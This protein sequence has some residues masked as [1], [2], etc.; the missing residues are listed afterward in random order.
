MYCEQ[1]IRKYVSRWMKG[2]NLVL[3]GSRE[4]GLAGPLSDIDLNI[5]LPEFEGLSRRAPTFLRQRTL[6]H[7]TLKSLYQ[8]FLSHPVDRYDRIQFKPSRNVSVLDITDRPTG[9]IIQFTCRPE[10]DSL[11]F[12]KYYMEEYPQLRPLYQTLSVSLRNQ[13]DYRKSNRGIGSYGLFVMILTA[14]VHAPSRFKKEELGG[15][16]KHVLDFWIRADIRHYGYAVDPPRI[17]PK[18]SRSIANATDKEA[19]QESDDPSTAGIRY[20]AQRNLK[21]MAS[22]SR[23]DRLCLQDPANLIN[24]LGSGGDR[25]REM[26]E[27][28]RKALVG[29]QADCRDWDRRTSEE[30]SQP[31]YD[32]V[33][34]RSLLGRKWGLYAAAREK[35]QRASPDWI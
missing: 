29:V 5:S 28:F 3:G 14:I 2:K 22:G 16:L 30:R 8:A 25:V 33:L 34:L 18:Y 21:Q 6:G 11:S 31:E 26:I 4:T 15:Q 9:L 17:F 1:E 32:M 24:D 27:Y 12:C 20:L 10:K 13:F 23:L 19:D 7:N 35:V